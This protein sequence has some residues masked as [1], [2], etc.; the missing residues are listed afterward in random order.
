MPSDKLTSECQRHLRG[1]LEMTDGTMPIE[2]D[3]SALPGRPSVA[4]VRRWLSRKKWAKL[5]EVRDG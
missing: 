3:P 5:L 1:T 2:V 4:A